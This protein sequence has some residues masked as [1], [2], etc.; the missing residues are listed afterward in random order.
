MRLAVALFLVAT[1]AV[2]QIELRP[3]ATG[4]DLP[5]AMAHAGDT[6]LF[7]VLQRGRVM[8]LSGS[9]ASTFLDIRTIVS[10]CGERGLLG[11]AFHP[12]FQENRFFYVFYTEL[13]GDLVVARY[14]A[15]ADASQALPGSAMQIMRIEHSQFGNHNGGQLAFGPDGYLYLA[16]GDGGSGGDPGNNA[17]NLQSHLGKILR[18]D[19]DGGSPYAI[20]P[21]NPFRTQAS[22]LPEIWAFGLRNPWRFSFDRQTGDLW[23]GDVGQGS[24]EEVNFQPAGSIGGENYGWRRMEGRHCFN[25][26]SNCQT[27]AMV[28]PVL[29]YSLEGSACAVVGGFRY[30][31]VRNLLLRG[32]YIYA[33]H[34]TGLISG[35]TPQGDGTWSTEVLLDAP[36][37]ISTFGEDI[38]GEIYVTDYAGGRVL[39]LVDETPIPPGPARRRAVRR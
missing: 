17:Q 24:W 30:R 29:E 31:G 11:L 1:S 22:T 36:F 5:V 34:C 12:R 25:P 6:R 28:L 13:G 23:I 20:P 32:T 33:D 4:L 35:A 21:S 39:Q 2:A 18:L 15:N 14:T 3:V 19:V 37:S 16:P 10:C 8:A 38:A 27:P 9:A 7:V 26:S